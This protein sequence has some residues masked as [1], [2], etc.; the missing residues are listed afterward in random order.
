MKL[1]LVMNQDVADVLQSLAAPGVEVVAFGDRIDS[2]DIDTVFVFGSMANFQQEWLQVIAESLEG[3]IVRGAS[4]S[5][6]L[7]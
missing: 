5:V 7:I 1:M 3:H 6:I 2:K 4:M